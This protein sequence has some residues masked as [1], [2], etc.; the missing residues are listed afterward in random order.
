[1]RARGGRR[2]A[3]LWTHTGNPKADHQAVRVYI[4]PEPAP[5]PAAA[6][7]P[8]AESEGADVAAALLDE[9]M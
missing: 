5:E 6:V 3:T 7:V 8:G 2:Q 1:M 4:K 9:V